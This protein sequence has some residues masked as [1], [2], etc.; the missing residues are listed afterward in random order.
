MTKVSVHTKVFLYCVFNIDNPVMVDN[1]GLYMSLV[2]TSVAMVISLFEEDSYQRGSSG[3][4]RS[5]PVSLW[6]TVI[7]MSPKNV[8]SVRTSMFDLDL[9]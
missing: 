3:F 4:D 5:S 7:H 2:P 6:E 9:C 1:I 8:L